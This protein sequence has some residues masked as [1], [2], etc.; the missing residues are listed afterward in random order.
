MFPNSFSQNNIS[1]SI[2][3]PIHNCAQY[4]EKCLNS[5]TNQTLKD[6]QI[7]CINDGSNDKSLEIL[8]D[9]FNNFKDLWGGVKYNFVIEVYLRIMVFYDAISKS[10]Y[11]KY[12]FKIYVTKIIS[13][14][15]INKNCFHLFSYAFKCIMDIFLLTT[16]LITLVLPLNSLQKL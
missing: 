3:I 6:I 7:I 12:Y 9:I 16:K 11:R 1:V 14:L 10:K 13:K 2:I 15:G 8:M 5:V 4:L